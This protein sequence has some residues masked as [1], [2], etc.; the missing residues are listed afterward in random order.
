M[1]MDKKQVKDLKI[2]L[3]HD[4]LDQYGG[5]ERVLEALCEMFPEAPIFTLL[6]DKERLRGKFADREIQASFLQKF[7]EFLRKRKKWLLPFMPTAPETFNLRDYDLI[8]SSSGAWSKG[9]I[10]R[11]NTI[12][13]SY[14]HS[15]MRF[16][17]D[18]NE[19]YLKQKKGSKEIGF[20]ARLI[21]NYIR[22]WDKAAS[23]RPDYLIA[24]SKYTQQRIEKYY[25]RDSKVIYPPVSFCHSERSA[26][27]VEESN[28]ENSSRSLDYARDDKSLQHYFLVVSRLSAYKKID[29]IIETF[30]KLG[31]P[32][33]IIG[34][35]EDEKRL[36]SLARKNISFLGFQKEENLQKIYAKARA[37]IFA[38]EDDF[39]IAPV[40]AMLQGTPVLALRRGGIL[41]T[42]IEGK[43]GE[44]FDSN[45]PEIIADCVRRFTEKENSYDKE[46]IKSRAGE[47]SKERFKRELGE[48]I[49]TVISL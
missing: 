30:N 26:S 27:E 16:V 39:G 22:I 5:A 28:S 37:F 15:P 7:P 2:A 40:E 6:Y 43:T 8:I 19:D 24:N 38:N 23:D 33:L 42:V 12:H 32:L 13:I 3:V 25:R 47:F 14:M 20:L 31:L 34:E 48:Y 9:I 44:F 36:K 29:K 4:F 41:E 10:T 49:G 17:W 46:D 1:A 45:E 21:L 11:L 18:A 35:G